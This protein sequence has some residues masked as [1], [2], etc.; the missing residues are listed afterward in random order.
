M[1]CLGYQSA[2]GPDTLTS[3]VHAYSHPVYADHAKATAICHG[4]TG[5][6]NQQTGGAAGAYK[7][8]HTQVV[9]LYA[10]C[11]ADHRLSRL[12]TGCTVVY[13]LY[14]C[15]Q[16]VQV[17]TAMTG[18]MKTSI[19]SLASCKTRSALLAGS[20]SP[21]FGCLSCSCAVIGL[22]LGHCSWTTLLE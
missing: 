20:P 2:G 14:S 9:Q 7:G 17:S 15:A 12:I 1:C 4:A 3:S 5:T 21:S 16:L 10:D 13:R 19:Q 8:C 11:T 6:A 18:Y 22:L